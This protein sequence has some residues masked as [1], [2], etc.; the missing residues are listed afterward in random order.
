MC[1]ADVAS[2]AQQSTLVPRDGSVLLIWIIFPSTVY[3]ATE[4]LEPVQ[5][6]IPSILAINIPSMPLFGFQCSYYRNTPYLRNDKG[7]YN[8][9]LQTLSEHPFSIFSKR[10]SCHLS[11]P[12]SRP[13]LQS[14]RPTKTPGLIKGCRVLYASSAPILDRGISLHARVRVNLLADGLRASPGGDESGLIA[15]GMFVAI[16]VIVAIVGPLLPLR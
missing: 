15:I 5:I 2:C 3:F 4:H 9:P 16:I 12:P 13:G 10:G 11:K 6:S 1:T 14:R 8:N 7:T